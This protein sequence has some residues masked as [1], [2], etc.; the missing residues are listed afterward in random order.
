MASAD[1]CPIT[2]SVSTRR[3]SWITVGFCGLSILFGMALSQTPIVSKPPLGQP[4]PDRKGTRTFV[5]QLRYLPRPLNQRILL[6]CANSSQRSRPSMTFLSVSS[7]PCRQLPPDIPSRVCPCSWLVVI[8]PRIVEL[9]IWTLFLLQRTCTPLIHA[10]AGRTQ[11]RCSGQAE[12]LYNS[13]SFSVA[14]DLRR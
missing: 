10:H 3:A 14:P 4:S 13:L 12:K 7:Q 6:C 1:F 5:A 11:F 9:I 8:V 2:P